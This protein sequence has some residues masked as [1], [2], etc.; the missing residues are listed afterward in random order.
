[1][2]K[3]AKGNEISWILCVLA[4]AC[5]NGCGQASDA[6]SRVVGEMSAP[7]VVSV[8]EAVSAKNVAFETYIDKPAS[9]LL[10]KA[11]FKDWKMERSKFDFGDPE[12]HYV[13]EGYGLE[14][15]CGSDDKIETI[16]LGPD[17]IGKD[18]EV[19][20]SEVPFSWT[21]KQVVDRFGTP[22]KSG[23]KS[24]HPTLGEYGGWDRFDKDG[25][26]IHFEYW[27]DKDKIKRITLMRP[28]VVP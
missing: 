1:M 18:S 20:L 12:I 6:T 9:A 14:L 11:P 10:E 8:E 16:F 22:S 23:G 28:D 2:G 4:F 17:R 5:I 13:F 7:E 19:L 24:S 21:Q 25:Y 3:R 27:H 15:I 26:T